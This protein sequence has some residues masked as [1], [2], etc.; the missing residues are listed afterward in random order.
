MR[1]SIRY[2]LLVPLL[3][4]LL[5]VV[6]MSTW[7]ALASASRAR[8]QIETQVHDIVHTVN[9][10]TYPLTEKV[11]HLMKGFSGADYLLADGDG[12]RWS[13]LPSADV[14]LPAP[15]PDAGEGRTV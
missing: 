4:L 6:G 1:W 3:T 5:G 15:D 10:S 12:H 9:Q 13:T 11:L 14:P 7:T 2:Q 8:R